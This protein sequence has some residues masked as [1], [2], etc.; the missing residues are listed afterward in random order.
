LPKEHR[1]AAAE[2][3]WSHDLRPVSSVRRLFFLAV[4]ALLV[5]PAAASAAGCRG[6]D[7]QVRDGNVRMARQATLCLLNRERASRGLRRLGQ[8]A[9]LRKAATGHSRDMVR[10]GFFDH[11]APTGA[12]MMTRVRAAGYL[13]RAIEY[14]VGENIGWGGGYLGTPREMVRAWMDSPGHRTNI[15]NRRFRDIGIGI[16]VGTPSGPGGATYTTDFGT[17]R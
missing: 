9:R 10:R 7:T 12:T 17:R 1:W 14:T 8:D 2:P 6:A 4:L 13:R 5:A 16:V 15:L 3:D 11:T